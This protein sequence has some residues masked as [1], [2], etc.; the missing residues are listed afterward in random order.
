MNFK[1]ICWRLNLHQKVWYKSEKAFGLWSELHYTTRGLV[2]RCIDSLALAGSWLY[3]SIHQSPSLCNVIQITGPCLLAIIIYCQE[4]I[5]NNVANGNRAYYLFALLCVV[6]QL[7]DINF[8]EGMESCCL[9]E[10]MLQHRYLYMKQLYVTK[11][12]PRKYFGLLHK[13]KTIS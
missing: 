3:V 4:P 8:M 10:K 11:M 6:C 2:Y 5:N 9:M 1:L 13:T 7:F 12:G